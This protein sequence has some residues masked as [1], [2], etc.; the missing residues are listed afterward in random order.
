VRDY[1][2]ERG[3]LLA[4]KLVVIPNGVDVERFAAAK[5]APLESLDLE[6][7][8]RMIVSIA[9]FDEQKGFGWLLEA[10][11]G[12]LARLPQHDLVL[13]GEGPLRW[14]LEA[15]VARLG[16]GQ[17]VRF[18]GFREDVAEIIAAADLVVLGSRW[19]GMP[20]VILE[21]MAG[22]RPVVCT[23]V[24]G[25]FELL[26]EN[27]ELQTAAPNDPQ[28]F[29]DKVVAIASDG[30]LAGRLGREN[31]ARAAERFT[32]ARMVEGYQQL[33]RTLLA[34]AQ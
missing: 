20:N 6:R 14:R 17:R 19:E 13:V 22:G 32:W 10:M 33:Y 21:A 3:G 23:K 29:A 9:R 5:P 2:I 4:E 34:A 26:G 11:R 7:Q 15:L 8:R 18:A 28:G 30:Q 31:Q 12:A 25:I 1:S 24:E 27:A 16:I